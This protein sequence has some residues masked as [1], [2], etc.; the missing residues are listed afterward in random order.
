MRGIRM[1]MGRKGLRGFYGLLA[2]F[3]LVL[4]GLGLIYLTVMER[5]SAGFSIGVLLG[6]A[7]II[8]VAANIGN[9]R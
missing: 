4:L 3:V 5:I 2:T 6:I 8:V 7:A 9:A 1:H